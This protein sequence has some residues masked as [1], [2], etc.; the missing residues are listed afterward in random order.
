ML[1]IG[2]FMRY[3]RRKFGR[4]IPVITPVLYGNLLVGRKALITG[5][6]TGIGFAIAEAFARNGADVV[7]AGRNGS[8][9]R[10]ATAKLKSSVQLRQGQVVLPMEMD[11]K[12]VAHFAEYV[13]K[14]CT[15]IGGELDILVNNAGISRGW[16]YVE[17]TEDDFDET[18]S[19]NLKGSY[20]LSQAVAKRMIE[21]KVC[22]NIL[23]IA[24]SSSL[25]PG[26]TPYI[27]SKWGIRS[28]TLGLAKIL[29][30]HGIVVNGLAPGPTNT[31][32]IL[33][34]GYDG[35]ESEIVPAGRLVTTEEIGNMAVV[36]ASSLGRMIV[37]DTVFVT[38]GSG[39]IT[40]DDVGYSF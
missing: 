18:I 14:A 1:G 16:K 28:F 38:G 25:R 8:R 33:K 9:L 27:L 29:I 26:N 11:L 3:A 37:G 2:R 10:E 17:V 20:F 19:T 31:K 35:V 7:L 32:M 21:A 15:S 34:D 4:K 39:V 22:G 6:G 23:N 36:L 40:V 13:E 30:K 12:D 24:S 5:A